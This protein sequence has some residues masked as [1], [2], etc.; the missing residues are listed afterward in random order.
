MFYLFYSF[1]ALGKFEIWAQIEPQYLK[2]WCR[3][4]ENNPKSSAHHF[5]SN[6]ALLRCNGHLMIKFKPVFGYLGHKCDLGK[7]GS[8]R[9]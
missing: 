2:S 7:L 6:D 1:V 3:E 9:A 5:A 4:T 8:N